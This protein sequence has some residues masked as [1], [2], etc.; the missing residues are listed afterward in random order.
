MKSLLKLTRF[1]SVQALK[2][3]SRMV[4]FNHQPLHSTVFSSS[5]T[6]R[7]FSTVPIQKQPVEHHPNPFEENLVEGITSFLEGTKECFKSGD[8]I[9]AQKRY[10]Q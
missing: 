2:Q 9:Q 10:E 4:L 8:Y 3:C 1:G 7:N 5:E 6:M